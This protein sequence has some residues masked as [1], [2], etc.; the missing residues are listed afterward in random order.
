[1]LGY[2]ENPSKKYIEFLKLLQ[3]NPYF[4]D[5]VKNYL[6]L[7]E[8][9]AGEGIRTPAG[10]P[11]RF[12]R[13]APWTARPPRHR[14]YYTLS[15]ISEFLKIEKLNDVIFILSLKDLGLIERNGI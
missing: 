12:S 10:L 13:P 3:E 6:K 4:R 1:M 8:S 14:I 5:F 9:N 11:H 2:G 15:P 7:V